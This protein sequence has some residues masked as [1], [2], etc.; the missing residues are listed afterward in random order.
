MSTIPE[1]VPFGEW[2]PDAPSFMS[3]GAMEAKNVVPQAKSYRSLNSLN[4]FT[5]ALS[6]ACLGNF[7]AQDENN[8]VF[9][10]AGDTDKLYELQ[11]TDT[12]TDVSGPSAPY[13]ASS[14]DFTK[15]GNRII[16]TALEVD[17]QY[18]DLGASSAWADLPA[19]PSAKV[20]ATVRD[21]VMF[22]DVSGQGPNFVQWSGYNNSELWTPSLA[23]QSDYQ[24]LFGR[25]GRVQRVVPGDYATIFLEHSIFRADYVGP[26]VIFQFDEVERNHGTPAPW[27]VVWSG[28]LTYYYGWDGFYAFDGTVSTPI[29]ANRVAKWV[30]G[31][32]ASD[33][34]DKM[35]G[36]VDRQ[37]RLIIWAFR[38]TSSLDYNNRIVIYNWSADR[39]S[40]AE[41]D[42]QVFSEVVSS[43][44]SLD[45]LD[46]PLPLGIDVES[47]PVDSSEFAG[48]VLSIS[49]FDAD[50]KAATFSGAPLTAVLDTA[51]IAG[52]DNRRLFT[53]S[54]RPLVEGTGGTNVTMQI[55]TRNQLQDN[56]SFSAVK[57]LNGI[58]GEV[59]VRADSRYQRF[60][61]NIGGGF[62]HA[63]G[64][65]PQARPS[66]GRR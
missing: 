1:I 34:V 21:F 37:N 33:A 9:N 24:E 49:A 15:F 30:E 6:D 66:T 26:P 17:P 45:G 39:W 60:R 44:V 16:A 4:A 55:G 56:V 14:W 57:S 27:S 38:T 35:R 63:D 20:C 42:T 54:V 3:E 12:W 5:N 32:M 58:N 62:S 59:S 48:G 22:G 11:N 31:E 8:V 10:F 64:V 13:A 53:N 46:V 47:I 29:S 28:G 40:Y 2:M 51:E 18:W 25:G 50:N 23:T 65:K 19:A 61:A 36:V 41:V 52:P 43:G 7:W